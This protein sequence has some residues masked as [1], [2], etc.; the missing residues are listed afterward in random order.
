M[1][2]SIPPSRSPAEPAQSGLPA[3]DRKR[4]APRWRASRGRSSLADAAPGPHPH[5]R[6]RVS[7]KPRAAG[8]VRRRSPGRRGGP[9]WGPVRRAVGKHP[10]HGDRADRPRSLRVRHPQR[11]QVPAS[12]QQVRPCGRRDLPALPG[13]GSSRSFGR[14]CSSRSGRRPCAPSTRPR[15][16]SCRRRARA[17]PL[18]SAA[19]SRWSILRPRSGPVRMKERWEH[20]LGALADCLGTPVV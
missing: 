4:Y 3:P 10:P 16:P 7:R 17:G 8:R 20:D 6:G 11:P 1:P 5:E 15:R 19:C 12:G 2:L 18:R 13:P 14:T 9:S